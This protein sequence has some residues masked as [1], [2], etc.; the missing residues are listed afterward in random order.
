M[1][2]RRAAK[3]GRPGTYVPDMMGDCAY[4]IEQ[5]AGQGDFRRP[6]RESAHTVQRCGSQRC[7]VTLG[8]PRV[9]VDSMSSGCLIELTLHFL[10]SQAEPREARDGPP[11]RRLARA[12]PNADLD[13]GAA[14][15]LGEGT[16]EAGYA[17]LSSRKSRRRSSRSTRRS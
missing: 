17:V 11:L 4:D 15:G 10:L 8:Y 6:E 2:A 14:P 13:L 5:L 3:L 1:L 7:G 16:S 12:R 9:R